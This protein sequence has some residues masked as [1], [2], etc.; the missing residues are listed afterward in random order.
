MLTI[1]KL[2]E[3]GANTDEGLGRCMGNEDFYIRMVLLTLQDAGF[4]RLKNA[5]ASNDL[6]TAFEAAHSLKGVFGNLALTPL[7][8]PASEMTELL[9]AGK[10]ADYAS[11]LNVILEE[12]KKLDTLAQ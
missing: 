1:E 9:R 8:E 7:F 12:K 11:Y 10:E 3:F 5:V 6:K 4:D 2:R